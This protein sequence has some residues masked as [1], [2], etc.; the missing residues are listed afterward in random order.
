[1]PQRRSFTAVSTSLL[2]SVLALS[3]AAPA[4]ASPYGHVFR[5]MTQEP[6]AP[7]VA[8]APAPAPAP[9]SAPAPGP[10]ANP[11]P[12]PAQPQPYPANPQPYA[13]P[14]DNNGYPAP[15]TRS[16]RKGMMIGGW[17]M[18]GASYLFTALIGAI[19]SDSKTICEDPARCQRLGY[20]MMIPVAG[21]FIATGPSDSATGSIFLGLTGVIQTAGLILG[22]VGT[23]QFVADGR[24]NQSVMNN[25]G[26]RLTRRGLRVNA[27][28]T[29]RG[30]AMVG[31]NYRF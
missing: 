10:Y 26:L 21:P 4:A 16:R 29:A 20:Y 9:T 30:G 24:R 8:P 5:N 6:V 27:T 18:L 25:D 2:A 15:A 23:A 17:T 14:N 31:L 11:Q 1:M 19:I 28:P 13:D 3:I 12:Y 22:I 7:D